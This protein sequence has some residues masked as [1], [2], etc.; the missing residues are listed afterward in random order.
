[1]TQIEIFENKLKKTGLYEN[2]LTEYAKLLK[3]VRGNF[4]R[5]QHCYTTAID[6]STKY[7]EDAVELIDFGIENYPDTWFPMYSAYRNKGLILERVNKYTEAYEAFL[8]AREYVADRKEY[9]SDSSADL[10]WP[11]MH[12]DN[13]Q[14]SDELETYRNEIVDS[15]DEVFTGFVNVE[16]RVTVADVILA[17]HYDDQERAKQKKREAQKISSPFYRSRLQDIL[18]GHGYKDKLIISKE[19]KN[20][21]KS[22]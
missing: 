8:K 19:C 18:D 4:Y 7:W 6:F 20:Y 15:E 11:L 1:M 21:L 22:V 17:L 13:F 2:A 3:R 14:Y 10:L 12:K 9:L 5:L 16:F